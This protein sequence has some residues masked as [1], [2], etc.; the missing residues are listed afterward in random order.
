VADFCS[1]Y[2]PPDLLIRTD[3]PNGPLSHSAS[4]TSYHVKSLSLR[5]VCYAALLPLL[6]GS[7]LAADTVRSKAGDVLHGKLVGETPDEIV[8][9][10]DLVGEVTLARKDIAS[11]TID[12]SAGELIEEEA[13]GV[14]RYFRENL[15]AVAAPIFEPADE[16]FDWIQLTSGE[17]LKGELR[18][19][20]HNVIEFD[21]DELDDLEID[22]DKVERLRTA[23]N[24]SVRIDQ[25]HTRTGPMTLR[26][27]QLS[28]GDGSPD[29]V[30]QY[31]L[32]SI[33]PEDTGYFTGWSAK[34]SL[35]TTLRGGIS[36]QRD[37]DINAVLKRRTAKRRFYADF[38]SSY[39]KTEG[40]VSSDSVR[41][42]L[43]FDLLRTQ[44]T[45][46]RAASLEFYRDPVQ[47]ISRRTTLGASY[48]YYLVDTR[49]RTWDI[50]IG[51]AW[52]RIIYVQVEDGRPREENEPAMVLSSQLDLELTKKLD[53][54]GNYS[55]QWANNAVGATFHTQT[56]LEYDLTRYLDLD[57]SFIWDRIEDQ[58]PDET[59]QV[60]SSDDY[61]L[62]IGLGLDY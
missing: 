39:S 3:S 59:G 1:I 18:A 16:D 49:K 32:I 26:K 15:E 44:R 42:N 30:G 52:Q 47:N 13:S 25:D 38:L 12:R 29:E 36:T 35:A 54:A 45:F 28:I 43:N 40:F 2:G 24:F 60:P 9:E 17:W 34:L 11:I 61:R 20:Y 5:I 14:P 37:L 27:G 8:F 53:L 33:A 21:S 48:G 62:T 51:P 10:S 23:G 56:K 46:I 41:S 58:V 50:S 22:W 6:G 4:V 7:Q 19:V 31:D 55:L 57:V